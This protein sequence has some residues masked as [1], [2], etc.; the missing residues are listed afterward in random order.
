MIKRSAG[1]LLP[2]VLAL[3]LSVGPGADSTL[4]QVPGYG[5]VLPLPMPV[6]DVA[7]TV[8]L[9]DL[10]GGRHLDGRAATGRVLYANDRV[11]RTAEPVRTARTRRSPSSP[12]NLVQSRGSSAPNS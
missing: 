2:G 7:L 6:E 1:V 3:I 8:S 4:T 10:L 9:D 5:G 11:G 12:Q